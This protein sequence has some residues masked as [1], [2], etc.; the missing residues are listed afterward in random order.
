[1]IQLA[2]KIK[3]PIILITLAVFITSFLGVPLAIGST[4]IVDIDAGLNPTDQ[5]QLADKLQS[6]FKGIGYFIGVVAVGVLIFNGFRLATATNEQKRAEV[7]THIMWTLGAVA[8]VALSLMI[9][10]FVIALVKGG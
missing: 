1:M 8:L 5:K 6:I 3:N 10:G 2:Q 4:D 7:K 9:V